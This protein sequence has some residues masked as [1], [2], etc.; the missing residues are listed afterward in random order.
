MSR[1]MQGDLAPWANQ[2]VRLLNAALT[3]ETDRPG[4]H[5]KG[6]RRFTE[7]VLRALNAQRTPLVFILLGEC[8]VELGSAAQ[9]GAPP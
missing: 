8:A 3:V 9:L 6:W 5:L 1:P 4:S 2:G 7:K